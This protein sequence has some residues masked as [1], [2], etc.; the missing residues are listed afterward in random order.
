MLNEN[1][2]TAQNYL[3]RPPL[4]DVTYDISDDHVQIQSP[5]TLFINE[6][7]LRPLDKQKLLDLYKKVIQKARERSVSISY[8]LHCKRTITQRWDEY[9]FVCKTAADIFSCIVDQAK[10]VQIRGLHSGTRDDEELQKLQDR[11]HAYSR[12]FWRDSIISQMNEIYKHLT[13]LLYDIQSGT[14]YV[15]IAA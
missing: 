15:K 11:G 14:E 9:E 7:L 2:N 13:G 10:A 3:L 5:H 8:T 1:R 4:T 6:M 12:L